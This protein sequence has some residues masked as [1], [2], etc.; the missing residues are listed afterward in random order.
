M[1]HAASDTGTAGMKNTKPRIDLRLDE[2]QKRLL[3]T[4]AAVSGQTLTSFLL[5]HGLQ[6]AHDVIQEY[7]ATKLTLSD[8][9]RFVELLENPAEPPASL[10]DAAQRYKDQISS[11]HG[12]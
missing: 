12:L 10:K 4:A 2:A 8:S 6:A 11:S 1:E 9:E 7:R 5:S 3:E